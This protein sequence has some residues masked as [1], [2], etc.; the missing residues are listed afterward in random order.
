MKP[1]DIV[2][3]LKM[4]CWKEKNRSIAGIAESVKISASETHAAIKRCEKAGLF[5]PVTGMPGSS[6]LEEFLVYGLKYVYPAEK[7]EPDRGMPTAH[8]APPLSEMLA[9]SGKSNETYVWPYAAGKVRGVSIIPLY[10]TIP[11][12]AEKDRKLYEMLTL[13]DAIRMGRIREVKIATDE[14]VKRI[15]NKV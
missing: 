13:I 4:L 3:M 1:Q 9:G 8:S 10:K 7:G 11:V 14:L 5:N 12:A 6:N 15:R 2:I